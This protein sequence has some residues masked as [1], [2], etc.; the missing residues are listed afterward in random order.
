MQQQR[1]S[2]LKL[3]GVAWWCQQ[4]SSSVQVQVQ[5]RLT[6]ECK[7]RPPASLTAAYS[8]SST[9][10][11][12]SFI[13]AVEGVQ[14]RHAASLYLRGNGAF[15]FCFPAPADVATV[16]CRPVDTNT[17]HHLTIHLKT[18]LRHTVGQWYR[19][20][21]QRPGA[22]MAGWD[23]WEQRC[24]TFSVPQRCASSSCR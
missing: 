9:R 17:I 3:A 23:V 21:G 13:C 15:I 4:V 11:P 8:S 20:P 7:R 12:W 2:L 19:L 22:G 14:K 24:S 5:D 6:C 10:S 18:Q 1:R 16:D